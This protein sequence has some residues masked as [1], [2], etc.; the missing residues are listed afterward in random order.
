MRES[1]P[2]SRKRGRHAEGAAV[3]QIKV[4]GSS[5]A[6]EDRG[7]GEPLLLLHGWSGT[8][9][10]WLLNLKAFSPRFR[11]IAPDLPGHGDSEECAAF[12]YT[13]DGMA[14]FLESF[15]RALRL[16]AFHL[17]GHAMG[18]CIAVRYAARFPEAIKKLILVSTPTRTVSLGPHALLPGAVCVTRATYGLRNEAFLKWRL[19]RGVHQPEYLDLDFA[20]ANV[21]AA[22][23]VTR[24]ALSE[25]TRIVRGMDLADDLANISNPALVVFGDR[26]R[27]V[28]PRE[29]Q[30][31]RRLLGRPYLAVLNACGHYPQC[32][33][34]E[35]FNQVALEFLLAEKLA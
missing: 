29:A 9:R 2:R 8:N 4:E 5:I 6:F 16:T 20:R 31:Q 33:K 11:V 17:M 15:R 12:P 19:Y 28:N 32:E 30:R 7:K 1:L 35:L 25:S 10:L 26:D 34:P 22:A 3:P 21:K 24:R 18:G 27:R 23:R 13:R 14:D